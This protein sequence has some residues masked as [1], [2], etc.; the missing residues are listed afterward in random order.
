MFKTILKFFKKQSQDVVHSIAFYPV[1]ISLTYLL[2]AIGGLQVENLELISSLKKKI[3][4]IFIED[5]ETA[6]SILSTIIGGILS[7]TVFSFTMVMV[8]LNQASSNFSPRLLPNLIS[9][10]KHH[11]I[12]NIHWH[13]TVLYYHFN[14]IRSLRY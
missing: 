8:V 10:K 11:Y 1:L 7:L 13:L 14:L 4:Y 2:L 6:R 9:N 12:G 5:Y 3:P